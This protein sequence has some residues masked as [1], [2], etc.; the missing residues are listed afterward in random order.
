[1]ASVASLICPHAPQRGLHTAAVPALGQYTMWAHLVAVGGHVSVQRDGHTA[2]TARTRRQHS[3]AGFRSRRRAQGRKAQSK[4]MQ[5]ASE[6]GKHTA[7]VM[8]AE[9]CRAWVHTRTACNVPRVHKRQ[10]D[11]SSTETQNVPHP[12]SQGKQIAASANAGYHRTSCGH[13]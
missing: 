2:G 5:H 8:N 1:V 7:A 6:Q 4:R 11:R 9:W 13:T 3:A 12:F 10:A